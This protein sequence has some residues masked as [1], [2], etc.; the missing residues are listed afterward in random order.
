MYIHNWLHTQLAHS[1]SLYRWYIHADG[2]T[3]ALVYRKWNGGKQHSTQNDVIPVTLVN[4]A[5][6]C[7]GEEGFLSW[8]EGNR[9]EIP[10]W[11][12]H[13][14]M[15]PLFVMRCLL[16][17][18]ISKNGLRL[19]L[20]RMRPIHSSLSSSELA[21]GVRGGGEKRS[22]VKSVWYCKCVYT[23]LWCVSVVCVCV[24]HLHAVV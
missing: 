18:S 8:F 11:E 14:V 21:F 9:S 19:M 17:W 7:G 23:C 4:V 13:N 24:S 15:G 6:V 12:A 5:C 2:D 22:S 16:C 20:A 1:Q 10:G 3:L